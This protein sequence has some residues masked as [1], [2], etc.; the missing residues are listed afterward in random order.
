MQIYVHYLSGFPITLSLN[1]NLW[2][3]EVVMLYFD[4]LLRQ[5]SSP[6]DSSQVDTLTVGAA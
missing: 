2:V 4:S 6:F 1:F 3:L 5:T